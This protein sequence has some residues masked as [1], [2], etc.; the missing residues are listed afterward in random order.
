MIPFSTWKDTN[1]E[2]TIL[3]G[4][5]VPALDC[6]VLMVCTGE[7]VGEPFRRGVVK[8]DDRRRGTAS[9]RRI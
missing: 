3:T 7:R 4:E 9:A 2:D 8:E 6:D 5:H 1:V